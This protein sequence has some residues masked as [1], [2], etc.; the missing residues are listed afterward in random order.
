[1]EENV[2][3]IDKKPKWFYESKNDLK[4]KRIKLNLYLS[5]I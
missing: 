2:F 4:K 1:M 3:K 5:F